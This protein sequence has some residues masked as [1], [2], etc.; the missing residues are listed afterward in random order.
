[1]VERGEGG[2]AAAKGRA[3]LGRLDSAGASRWTLRL[4]TP[5]RDPRQSWRDVLALHPEAEWVAPAFHDASG[6]ELLPTGA[7]VVRFRKKPSDRALEAFA[8]DEALELE[9]RNEF[10]PEQAAFHP[11]EPRE[12]SLPD[13]GAKP[14]GRPDVA[15]AWPATSSRYRKV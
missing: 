6:A 2:G 15:A 13:L 11:R 5:A 14:A 1:A 4:H 9:R 7:V 12:V 8:R 10:V 3:A